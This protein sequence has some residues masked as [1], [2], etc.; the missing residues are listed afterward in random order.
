MYRVLSQGLSYH[1]RMRRPN[2]PSLDYAQADLRARIPVPSNV[3]DGTPETEPQPYYGQSYALVAWLD[4]LFIGEGSPWRDEWRRTAF[5]PS[6]FKI[7]L[8]AREFWRQ[9][10]MAS[11]RKDRAA[12]EAFYLCMLLGFRGEFREDPTDSAE[13]AGLKTQ[14]LQEWR[15]RFEKEL[16]LKE[17]ARWDKDPPRRPEPMT[18]VPPLTAR[19]LLPWLKLALIVVLGCGVVMLSFLMVQRL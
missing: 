7:A 13:Q 8:R 3:G 15:D 10:T 6:F 4:E 12:L 11:E 16:G 17:P 2:P 5:E 18:D 14:R 1:A 9:A 19:H